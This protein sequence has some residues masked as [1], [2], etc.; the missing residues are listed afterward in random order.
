[1]K[2][3]N[4][5]SKLAVAIALGVVGLCFAQPVA[6]Q[7]APVPFVVT[8]PINI[9]NFNFTPVAI[10]AGKRL[11]IDFISMSG[12]AQTSGAYVQPI[13]ILSATLQGGSQNLFYFAPLQDP[14]VPG[15]YYSSQQ[16]TI[17]ADTLSA[18]P[19][20]AGFTPTFMSFSVVIS[21]HLIAAPAPVI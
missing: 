4:K 12:A 18:S 19:A 11:V 21:G 1:L 16:T 7:T 5:L 2:V 3:K 13:I 10:P 17:Y 6:A 15:Q 14:N 20:F 9:N 8:V